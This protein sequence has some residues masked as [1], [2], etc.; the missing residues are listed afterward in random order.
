[1]AIVVKEFVVRTIV[2]ENYQNCGGCEDE[3][4]GT[5]GNTDEIIEASVDKVLKILKKSKLR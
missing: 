2:T 4:G 5:S 3:G 1:M